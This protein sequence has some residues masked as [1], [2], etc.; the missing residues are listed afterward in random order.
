[1]GFLSLTILSDMKD[2]TQ[3][4]RASSVLATV[5]HFNPHIIIPFYREETD[6]QRLISK[7]LNWD[8]KPGVRRLQY[9]CLYRRQCDEG[10]LLS[11][12]LRMGVVNSVGPVVRLSGVNPGYC[13]Y[14]LI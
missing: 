14:W 3:S 1:M 5:S 9:R 6:S 4:L 8:S 11:D 13:T 7:W 2:K 12:E 10:H